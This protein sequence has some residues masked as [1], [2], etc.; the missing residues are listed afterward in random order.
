MQIVLTLPS[1]L[2]SPSAPAHPCLA[3][4]GRRALFHNWWLSQSI[5][6]LS[7]RADYLQAPSSCELPISP[8]ANAPKCAYACQG[9]REGGREGEWEGGRRRDGEKAAEARQTS[10][11]MQA[12]GARMR[13]TRNGGREHDNEMRAR[14]RGRS[15]ASMHTIAQWS[16]R[17]RAVTCWHMLACSL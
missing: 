15:H 2:T 12:A 14:E 4:F 11:S 6:R 3:P 7:H 9:G 8:R 13:S 16:T 10:T 1:S 5:R 17:A